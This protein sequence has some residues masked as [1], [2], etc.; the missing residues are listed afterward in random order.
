ML[1]EGAPTPLTALA[2]RHLLV[3]QQVFEVNHLHNDLDVLLGSG[4]EV[5]LQVALP[6]QLE[7]HLFNGRALTADAAE[8]M[9]QGM[10]LTLQ[11]VFNEGF[12]LRRKE[13][14]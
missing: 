5:M 8:F 11:S 14:E 1:L 6:L 10:S 12:S 2:W 4:A 9:P 7:H 3:L 13:T